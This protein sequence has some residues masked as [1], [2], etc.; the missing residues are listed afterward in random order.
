MSKELH[1]GDCLEILQGIPVGAI[2]LIYIDPPF[3]SQRVY[4]TREGVT[5][6]SDKW[7]SREAYLEYLRLRVIELR[8]V[9]KD[10]GSFYLHCDPTMS[11]YLKIVLDTIFDVEN[12]CN[13]II[14]KRAYTVKGNFGQGRKLFDIN[15]DTIFFYRKTKNNTFN[16][17]YTSYKDEYV[18]KFYKYIEPDTGRRYSLISMTGPGGASK[19]NPRY[20][21]MGVTRYWR[22]SEKKMAELIKD[23]LVVQTKYGNVPRRKQYLDEGK[24]VSLQTLW[25]D[26]R[27]L[28][29]HSAERIGYPTQKPLALMERIIK[30][31]SN[32]GDTVLD[33]FCGCGSFLQA[34][35]NFDRNW[36][37][38]DSSEIAIQY[39]KERLF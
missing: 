20:E 34:A 7:G 31:S 26:I 32:K 19:G 16:H 12:F 38:I 1:H 4:K 23:N 6:F 13:E 11:H 14:W 37:G 27:A 28:S 8:R 39:C 5:A 21:V 29:S 22:Y 10:T 3:F 33:A 15:T 30:A 18:R 17:I 25:D 35:Q 2:D 36:I 9:L 24:G